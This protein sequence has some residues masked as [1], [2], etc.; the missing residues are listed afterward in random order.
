MSRPGALE[1]LQPGPL[2]L[3]QDLGRPGLA[4]LGVGPSGAADRRSHALANRLLGQDAGCATVEITLGGLALRGVGGREVAL[5]GAP[6]EARVDG[7]PVGH[8]APFYLGDGQVL[9]LA[10]PETGLRTYLA[11]HGG[12]DLPPVLGSR[13]TDT[14]SGIG[15]P[16]LRAGEVLPLGEPSGEPDVDVAPVPLPAAGAVTL[17]ITPGPRADWFADPAALSQT[18]WSVS[19]RTDRV[20][21]RLDGAPLQRHPDREGA[22]LPSE[23]VVRGAVQVPAGGQPVLFLA[24]HPVTGGYPVV[25]VVRAADIDLAAQARPGQEVRLRWS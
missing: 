7:I 17:R 15:P 20:G 8:A 18:R 24:D 9:R 4:S 11:A 25:A 6:A 16:P 5:T 23:G 12:I 13:S 2:A 10:R 19:P 1:V 21:V 22:E 3:V 14:L